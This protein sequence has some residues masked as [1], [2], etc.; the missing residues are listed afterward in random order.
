MNT[1]DVD[2]PAHEATE[3]LLLAAEEIWKKVI[4]LETSEYFMHRRIQKNDWNKD[5]LTL[6]TDE[7][8]F[9]FMEFAEHV[10]LDVERFGRQLHSDGASG[11]FLVGIAFRTVLEVEGYYIERLGAS[12]RHQ[13]PRTVL[14][15]IGAAMLG[16]ATAKAGAFS[17][18]VGGAISGIGSLL[19]NLLSARA[20]DDTP[21]PLDFFGEFVLN[22]LD[23]SEPTTF[24]SL[25]VQTRFHDTVLL[26]I[27]VALE[28]K[29]A[30]RRVV[31]DA[32]NIGFVRVHSL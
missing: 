6:S 28:E 23:S 10:G 17:P 13:V 16:I 11:R 9:L 12:S 8:V 14:V 30:I 27:L 4:A 15:T 29:G 7:C 19:I 32:S 2:P 18:E 3:G 26:K 20:E 1:V 24:A 21:K 31:M 25:Q 5:T 22:L